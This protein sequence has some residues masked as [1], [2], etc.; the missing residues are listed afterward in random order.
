MICYCGR[1]FRIRLFWRGVRHC[2]WGILGWLVRLVGW[3]MRGSLLWI[4]NGDPYF[5]SVGIPFYDAM[6][7][8]IEIELSA[9]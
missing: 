9:L 1:G 8:M 5:R 2:R 6:Q 7:S 4:G 3:E